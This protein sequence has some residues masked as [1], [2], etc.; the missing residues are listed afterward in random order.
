MDEDMEIVEDDPSSETVD[1]GG[2]GSPSKDD[3]M[4]GSGPGERT[5]FQKESRFLKLLPYYKELQE[6]TEEFLDKIIRNLT[7]AVLCQDFQVG[8]ILY[9]KGLWT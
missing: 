7:K 4:D 1:A 9:T 3:P 2:S 5:K 6:E 8:G